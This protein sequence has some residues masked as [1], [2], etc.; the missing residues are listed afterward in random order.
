[1]KGISQDSDISMIDA[2]EKLYYLAKQY[3]D[4]INT[5]GIHYVIHQLKIMGYTVLDNQEFEY[6]EE[7]TNKTKI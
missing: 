4:D 3:T 5:T 7:N 6:E 2:S 1:M